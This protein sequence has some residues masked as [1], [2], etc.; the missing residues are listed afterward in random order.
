MGHSSGG[1]RLKKVSEEGSEGFLE[2][3]GESRY[4]NAA[5]PVWKK[6]K[7]MIKGQCDPMR[8]AW[9]GC[10]VAAWTAQNWSKAIHNSFVAAASATFNIPPTNL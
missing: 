5:R 1:W 8:A 7:L 2:E 3:E 6:H 10:P 9:T 4:K